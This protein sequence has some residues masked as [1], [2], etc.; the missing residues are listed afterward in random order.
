MQRRS[1]LY[2]TI[3]IYYVK[4]LNPCYNI[5]VD[6]SN[7]IM[8]T[9]EFLSPPKIH[10]ARTLVILVLCIVAIVAFGYLYAY[11]WQGSD[12]TNSDTTIVPIQIMPLTNLG[13]TTPQ[14][15][16]DRI[17]E[18]AT[19]SLVLSSDERDIVLKQFGGISSETWASLTA[20]EREIVVNAL[21]R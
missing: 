3:H 9:N 8:D 10:H 7:I 12:E 2:I 4:L 1:D 15:L 16:T 11:V 5:V 14:E 21:N 19:A 20:E 18:R 6:C 17:I 13:S